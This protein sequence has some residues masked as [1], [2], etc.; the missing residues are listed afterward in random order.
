M[1]EFSH[2]D[3][4]RLE[5]T[6]KIEELRR[7]YTDHSIIKSLC[8][9]EE[10]FRAKSIELTKSEMQIPWGLSLYKVLNEHVQLWN[11]MR[12]NLT[13]KTNVISFAQGNTSNN[14]G[15]G[16][17]GWF[18]SNAPK[19]GGKAGKTKKGN[20]SDKGEGQKGKNG[21]F[22]NARVGE[23]PFCRKFNDRHCTD[24]NC[25]FIDQCNAK[26]TGGECLRKDRPR[27]E[28]AQPEPAWSSPGVTILRK[29]MGVN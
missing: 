21:G 20:G 16:N 22:I 1:C 14:Q 6:H 15:Q 26:L 9:T 25:R 27:K 23:T 4:Y 7:R 24:A 12:E 3:Q 5:Y 19:G 10:A 18:Q 17:S 8:M 28:A 11:I 29:H 13:N 2:A